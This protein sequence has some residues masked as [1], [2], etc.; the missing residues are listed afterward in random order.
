MKKRGSTGEKIFGLTMVGVI[1]FLLS[2]A[3]MD[4]YPPE[5]YI[6]DKIIQGDLHI[7]QPMNVL[8][9]QRM[10]EMDSLMYLKYLKRDS[11]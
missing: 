6:R 10:M 4:E 9:K 7:T 1:A 2:L 5:E 11:L 8:E 3:I